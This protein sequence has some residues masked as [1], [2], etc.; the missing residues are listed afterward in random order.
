MKKVNL[1]VLATTV[2]AGISLQTSVFASTAAKKT[3][4]VTA[5]AV[6]SKTTTRNVGKQT[7]V[8]DKPISTFKAVNDQPDEQSP[9]EIPKNTALAV[10]R[11]LAGNR[12]IVTM[13]G[14]TTELVLQDPQKAIYS[15][16][17]VANNAS[18][19]DQLTHSSL[20]WAKKITPQQLRAIK[21]YTGDGYEAM[22]Q[23]LRN[24][25]K[26]I[27]G[28]I[29]AKIKA[30]NGG[31]R[32]FKLASPLT[33][34]RGT[35]IEGV[36]HSLD[37]QG[38]EVGSQYLDPAYSSTT[39]KKATAIQFSKHVILKI[40]IPEGY[41]GAYVDPISKN[42]G[43]KEYLLDA[44]TRMIVTR[45]QKGYTTLH[46]KMMV[47]KPGVKAEKQNKVYHL[48]YWILTLNLAK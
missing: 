17:S 47:K 5:T 16:K 45:L 8:T 46:I 36:K 38:I 3:P 25:N 1:M 35:S 9:V 11:K 43:E 4:K 21:Y 34:F 23:A 24:A 2:L 19:I 6:T 37:T 29:Q 26:K 40:N 33:V 41:H 28:K 15:F 14:N 18:K 42:K 13:P 30:A 32:Q 22:N 12:Y 48:K 7:V 10:Q 31:L 27:N 44:G 39:L 20:R